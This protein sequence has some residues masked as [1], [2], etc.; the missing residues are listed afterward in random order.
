MWSKMCTVIVSVCL[1]SY[2]IG[3]HVQLLYRSACTVIASVCL[4]SYCIGLLVSY[5]IGLLVQLLYRSACTV[6]VSVFMYSYCIGLHVQLLSE[7]NEIWKFSTYFR[8]NTS[9]LME[10]YA[11]GAELFCADGRT[12]RQT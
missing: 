8:K 4:Y 1:Y 5:C 9:K 10:I 11:V 3:L 6:I 2:C 12:E 7:F